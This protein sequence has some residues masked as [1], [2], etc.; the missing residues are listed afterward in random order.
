MT[1]KGFHIEH[2]VHPDFI[3]GLT[4][5]ALMQDRIE[6]MISCSARKEVV[7]S[8]ILVDVDN[9][10][11]INNTI[12]P[13]S[14]D[15]ILGQ[16]G[17][18]LSSILRPGD[19]ACRL[20]GD[21]FILVFPDIRQGEI[22]SMVK[23]IQCLIKE[24]FFVGNE[25]IDLKLSIGSSTYPVDAAH[26]DDLIHSADIALRR[27]KDAGGNVF[28]CFD[29]SMS[30]QSNMLFLLK[31]G[32]SKGLDASEFHLA[33][34]P[35]VDAITRKIL[36]V[37]SLL[38]WNHPTRGYISPA[39]F[40][41]AAE[42]T[43]QIIRLGDFALRQS[44]LAIKGWRD[45]GFDLSIS[46]NISSIQICHPL[47]ATKV[48]SLAI[49]MGIDPFWIELEVTEGMIIDW[50]K[51]DIKAMISELIEFGFS[52][53]LDDFGTGYSNLG[54]LKRMGASTVKID[55]SF[56]RN[57][58]TDENDIAIIKSIVYLAN[59]FGMSVVAEGV[60]TEFQFN[61]VKLLGC[62]LIQGY[63]TGK[64][65]SWQS[66]SDAVAAQQRQGIQ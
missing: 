55:Q 36:G 35:K 51:H 22:L 11:L 7:F 32:I 3:T 30:E 9:F 66:I 56:V 47:F 18:R 23:K 37:E 64:P 27:A 49:E 26:S 8:I 62:H 1:N 34:Q 57:I 16:L 24:S 20:N 41:S 14:G 2:C 39:L 60:E 15:V 46:I 25:R 5:P 53:S 4:N 31:K 17:K 48:K 59:Q 12:G 42:E 63:L 10:T 58:E 50:D 38:R 44:F 45:L 43:G 6:Q 21:V 19:T 40:I 65:M 13:E 54:Y 28:R 29:A 33:F 52:L 61:I